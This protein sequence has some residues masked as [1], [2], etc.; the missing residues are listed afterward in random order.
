ME[1]TLPSPITRGLSKLKTRVTRNTK[2]S[3]TRDSPR[4]VQHLILDPNILHIPRSGL[5]SNIRDVASAIGA[6]KCRFTRLSN[7]TWISF[8]AAVGV[9]SGSIFFCINYCLGH[10]LL[11]SHRYEE[12]P[13]TSEIL[14]LRTAR[15]MDTPQLLLPLRG[16][17]HREVP[18]G[19]TLGWASSL[20]V[21]TRQC[22]SWVHRL[23]AWCWLVG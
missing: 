13:V 15:Y 18:T 21:S 5:L 23:A 8:F 7:L 17:L 2:E 22:F 19:P 6:A 14:P 1:W 12:S 4:V 9:C 20:V 3:S 10:Q 16:L 11:R